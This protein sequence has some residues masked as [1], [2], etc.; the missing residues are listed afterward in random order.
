[1]LDSRYIFYM[2]QTTDSNDGKEVIAVKK[3]GR[4]LK[5]VKL[6]RND[7]WKCTEKYSY[8]I[9]TE[10]CRTNEVEGKKKIEEQEE[11]TK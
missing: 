5:M 4:L 8:P 11:K 7:R 10:E 2:L 6:K 3:R 9:V 1:M